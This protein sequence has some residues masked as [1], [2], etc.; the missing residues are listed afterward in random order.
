MFTARMTRT[1]RYAIVV[2]GL[3]AALAATTAQ[4]AL[5]GTTTENPDGSGSATATA[6]AAPTTA[7][8]P[9]APAPTEPGP[10]QAT[11]YPAAHPPT[12]T[13][14]G[15]RRH[16]GVVI[17]GN[18]AAEPKACADAGATTAPPTSAPPAAP[19]GETTPPAAPE[20]TTQ[21]PTTGDASAPPSG[22]VIHK[23]VVFPGST[24]A[25]KPTAAA[26]TAAL[27]SI[28][29]ATVIRSRSVST[30]VTVPAGLPVTDPTEISILFG[31]S[32]SSRLT[33]TYNQVAGNRF[34]FNFPAGDGAARTENVAVSLADRAVEGAHFGFVAK[35]PVE[36]LY[37]ATLSPLTFTLVNDCDFDFAGLYAQDSEPVIHWGDD[38]GQEA[39]G[40]FSMRAFNTITV[41]KFARTLTAISAKDAI[42]A[43]TVWWDEIDDVPQIPIGFTAHVQD[44]GPLLPSTTTHTES[45][46][47]HA[48]TDE[49]CN[50][51]FHYSQTVTLLTYNAL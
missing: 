42:T 6:A 31:F 46:S 22:P 30:I 21:A 3:T 13:G 37:D 34:V 7:P 48:D 29:N 41:N 9:V 10:Q 27:S 23:G 28:A 47:T 26:P 14:H 40:E 24:E 43:P 17:A 11:C 49:A 2:L 18:A 5:A 32:G 35:V 12:P 25:P 20:T 16:K 45:F 51:T 15:H 50:G 1:A 36:A 33:Q 4:S 8:V 44:G 38:R 39:T 19:T